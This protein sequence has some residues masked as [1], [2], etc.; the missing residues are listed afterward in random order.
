MIV[1]RGRGWQQRL[2]EKAK[3]V[4]LGNSKAGSYV[5]SSTKISSRCS[6]NLTLKKKTRKMRQ[7]PTLVANG[8]GKSFPDLTQ[9]QKLSNRRPIYP[10]AHH[11]CKTKSFQLC[12]KTLK[13]SLGKQQYFTL[14]RCAFISIE[15]ERLVTLEGKSVRVQR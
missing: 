7:T 5:L 13:T 9:T 12:Q 8:D 6:K 4:L 14:H 15:R 11:F 3:M 1:P 10:N 2:R